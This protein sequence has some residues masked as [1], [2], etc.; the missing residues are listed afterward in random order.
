[1]NI[2]ALYHRSDSEFAY[3]YSPDKFHIRL[4]TAK[5]DIREVS[6]VNGDPYRLWGEWHI[7]LFNEKLPMKIIAS[8]DANDYWMVEMSAKHKR[9]HYSFL[10]VGNDGKEMFFC[11]KGVYP[12]RKPYISN[13]NY[14]FR[15]PYLHEIDMIK[16][17]DWVRNTVWYQIFPERYR[18]GDVS[19][20][21]VGT[22]V[23][24]SKEPKLNDFFGGDLQGII[25]KLG[26]IKSLGFNGIYLCPIFK[27][28][29]NHKYDTTDYFEIDPAFG[30]KETL[31]KLVNECHKHGI[32][33][34]L[35]AVFNHIGDSSEQWRDIV[36]NGTASKYASW[37]HIKE[38]PVSYAET[39]IVGVADLT[40]DSF[41]FTHHMPKLNTANPEVQ[42]Y[43][44][45]VARFW[46]EECEIDAW[47]LDV[48]N[49]VDHHFWK[50]FRKEIT[51][52]KNEIFILG[53]IWQS[54]QSWLRGD[55]IHAVM[56]Y[57]LTE[58]ILE[59]FIRGNIS[60]SEMI[61]TMNRQFMLYAQQTNEVMLNLLDSHDTPRL[62]T[63]ANGNGE[64]VK[65]VLAFMFLQ[66]GS[67]CI[68]Y[69]TEIG[70]FGGEEP[71]CR[72]CM[73]WDE[74]KWDKDMY[75]FIA[76]LVAFRR[77]YSDI[78]SFSNTKWET[79]DERNIIKLEK[80]HNGSI[81]VG[82]FNNGTADLKIA[83]ETPLLSSETRIEK[84]NTVIGAGG[85]YI[86]IN[87][88]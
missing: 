79:D 21:P 69:G 85:F 84:N 48:A 42:E 51:D 80:E 36:K 7:D 43:L 15:F 55:E 27:S 67:P 23:W 28:P 53:E 25:D 17:P 47:R 66:T 14:Y 1:M 62:M 24:N 35:D 75:S 18:N 31:K 39:D 82:I 76:S 86:G 37:F 56:N 32:K 4:R 22:L 58:A 54:P 41:A 10:I 8:T 30:T 57:S 61:T 46:I 5:D 19:N 12:V 44:L 71:G 68:Y 87:N 40:Y 73:E 64:L 16:T 78:I 38:F 70:M 49:E 3:L 63:V 2:A 65:S 83:F 11:E 81:L 59:Y 72:G 52:L 60:A 74:N 29:S 20:D 9:L 33:V 13:H 6:L 77:K 26:H 34:M 45:S 88:F 50:R